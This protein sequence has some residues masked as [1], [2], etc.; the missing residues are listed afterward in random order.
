MST[1]RRQ[2]SSDRRDRSDLPYSPKNAANISPSTTTATHGPPVRE[3]SSNL[4]HVWKLDKESDILS[5]FLLLRNIDNYTEGRFKQII[6]SDLEKFV[7]AVVE[8]D[9]KVYRPWKR[10]FE[11]DDSQDMHPSKKKR[12]TN[13]HGSH[14]APKK[15]RRIRIRL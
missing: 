5:V 13:A 6:M 10:K 2:A 7:Q 14:G 4:F 15:K 12:A 3:S 1:Q 11:D 8:K 9:G